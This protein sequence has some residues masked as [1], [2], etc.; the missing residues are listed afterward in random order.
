MAYSA[1]LRPPPPGL[2]FI[3]ALFGALICLVGCPR[4]APP[5]RDASP[6]ATEDS[7]DAVPRGEPWMPVTGPVE[8]P[9]SGLVLP[10]PEGWQARRGRAPFAVEARDPATGLTIYLGTW[11]GDPEALKSRVLASPEGFVDR[12]TQGP[13]AAVA[14][15]SPWISSRPIPGGLRVGWYFEHGT[16]EVAVEAELPGAD[17]EASWRQLNAVLIEARGSQP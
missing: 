1:A 3:L 6:E 2:S 8:E 17:L 4:E 9:R 15:Q 11:S 7:L 10:V 12:G 13:L 14:G 5:Q 16:H